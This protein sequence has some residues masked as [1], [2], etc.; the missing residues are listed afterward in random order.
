MRMVVAS[1]L[2]L[3]SAAATSAAAAPA[4][5]GH[6]P[7]ATAHDLSGQ[8]ESPPRARVRIRVTPARRLVRECDFRLV[9]EVRAGGTYVVPRERCWWAR[10]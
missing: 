1:C 2:L 9:R 3:I 10:Q 5:D 4:G 7:A 6:R 8:A